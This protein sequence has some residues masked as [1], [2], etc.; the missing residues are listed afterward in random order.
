MTTTAA[1]VST[2]KPYNIDKVRE[3][4]S[5]RESKRRQAFYRRQA[6]ARA[7]SGWRPGLDSPEPV[8]PSPQYRYVKEVWSTHLIVKGDDGDLFKVPYQV[9]ANGVDVTFGAEKQVTEQYVELAH[10]AAG[11]EW[12]DL[13][14][15]STLPDLPN[16]K[17]KTNWVEQ[18]G[19]LPKYIERIAKHLRSE[20]GFTTSH[21]IATAVNTVKRW[22]AGGTVQEHGGKKVSAATQAKAAAALAEWEAKRAKAKSVHLAT[23]ST[24]LD[25][26]GHARVS[27]MD[28][29][30]VLDRAARLDDPRAKAEVRLKVLDLA[31]GLKPGQRYI[32]GWIKIG[33]DGKPIAKA[34]VKAVKP[35]NARVAGSRGRLVDGLTKEQH[36]A[37]VDRLAAIPR[38]ERTREQQDQFVRSNSVLRGEPVPARSSAPVGAAAAASQAK[39]SADIAR[40]KGLPAGQAPGSN[41]GMTS[42]KND[43]DIRQAEK[44]F[45]ETTSTTMRKALERK[46]DRLHTERGKDMWPGLSD[47]AARSRSVQDMQYRD[48]KVKVGPNW[49]APDWYK[50][51][52]PGTVQQGSP[53]PVT[54]ALKGTD[55]AQALQNGGSI[56]ERLAARKASG[57][58]SMRQAKAEL[59]TSERKANERMI[60][61]IPKM[62][63]KQLGLVIDSPSTHTNLKSAARAELATR[64]R[65]DLPSSNPPG[66]KLHIEE[67]RDGRTIYKAIDPQGNP[68]VGGFATKEKAERATLGLRTSG[69]TQDELPDR[70]WSEIP[71]D[72]RSVRDGQRYV[73][74]MGPNGT[75]LRPWR[76]PA[77]H[78]PNGVKPNPQT[79]AGASSLG[80]FNMKASRGT[81]KALGIKNGDEIEVNIRGAVIRGT[82]VVK[83]TSIAIQEGPGGDNGRLHGLGGT[84]TKV[85][86]HKITPAA[87]HNPPPAPQG[88]ERPKTAAELGIDTG[89][90]APHP[91]KFKPGERPPVHKFLNTQRLQEIAQG[92]NPEHAEQAKAILHK[93]KQ[94]VVAGTARR[95]DEPLRGTQSKNDA[96]RGMTERILARR[97]AQAGQPGQVMNPRTP[98][99]TGIINRG[100]G[101]L[102]R[103]PDGEI[104]VPAEASKST[105]A[106]QKWTDDN[107]PKV[108][109]QIA[110]SRAR[111][112]S[113]ADITNA[114]AAAGIPDSETNA[115]PASRIATST[116]QSWLTSGTSA[117]KQIATIELRKRNMLPGSSN[118]EFATKQA[119]KTLL[120][121]RIKD[122][123]DLI[124]VSRPG[125]TRSRLLVELRT[126]KA[127]RKELG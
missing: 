24:R 16:K 46:F 47:E 78:V 64:H 72:Y 1:P 37:R 44:A 111:D 123:Q 66:G 103:G 7:A 25:A 13:V 34:A 76:D 36:A 115:G 5:A 2:R 105:E 20:Q 14:S 17:N 124:K 6:E 9:A 110:K 4:Y 85:V 108:D 84:A 117:Q 92:D 74:A 57:P 100:N 90:P 33:P 31:R 29:A 80:E 67:K 12:I 27:T 23:R 95:A 118:A 49:E 63:D 10:Q 93:R 42:H 77:K 51:P 41:G 26:N 71:A 75:T 28:L 19:G 69:H 82:A 79:S 89:G 102:L 61:E 114:R 109:K 88:R 22:A 121:K 65:G 98:T 97:E 104:P 125:S 68:V 119:Q 99:G 54:D 86:G 32:H 83:G 126:L 60:A 91:S 39:T 70:P 116:L 8:G 96:A 107:L 73:L 38:S 127:K 48:G 35:K 50:G 113:S 59:N 15:S 21:A 40:R 11:A 53:R 112:T 18:A 81:F 3:A 45:H 87:I 56:P 120:D 52:R 106:L 101:L 43:A 94:P 122:K 30:A 62:T 58:I 55:A